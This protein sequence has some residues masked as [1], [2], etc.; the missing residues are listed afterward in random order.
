MTTLH[1]VR[2]CAF[3]NPSQRSAEAASFL[4][5]SHP[6]RAMWPL[7]N[8]AAALIKVKLNDKNK[9]LPMRACPMAIGPS[10]RNQQRTLH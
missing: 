3:Y 2:G 5:C 6:G 9:P 10:K 7:A 4:V 1:H 8:R